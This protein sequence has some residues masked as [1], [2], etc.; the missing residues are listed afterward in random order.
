[1]IEGIKEIGDIIISEAPEKFLE[2]LALNVLSEKQGRKQYIVIINFDYEEV[3][4]ET[5][6]KY[7]WLDVAKGNKPQIYLT[8][9]GNKKFTYLFTKTLREIIKYGL[10]NNREVIDFQKVVKK[11]FAKF[12]NPITGC[13]DAR[14]FTCNG[15]NL[16]ETVAA[17]LIKDFEKAE[18]KIKLVK[19]KSEK[20]DILKELFGKDSNYK[21]YLPDKIFKQLRKN[22]ELLI[23]KDIGMNFLFP[24]KQENLVDLINEKFDSDIVKITKSK[25]LDESKLSFLKAICEEKSL[26]YEDIGL[27]SLRVLDSNYNGILVAH[28]GYRKLLEY[29]KI[30]QIFDVRH[31]NKEYREKIF[32]GVCSLCGEETWVSSNTT[33]LRFKFYMTDK[34]GFSSG[35]KGNFISNYTLC[36]S[37]YQKVM[38]G[39][40]FVENNLRSRIEDVLFYI[41]PKFTFHS[42]LS[43]DRL[44]KWGQYIKLSFNSAINLEG[45]AKFRD[46]VDNYL[47]CD[48]DKNSVILDLLFYRKSQAELRILKLVKD[49]PPSRLDIL[50]KTASEIKNK[51]DMLLGE[52][53]RWYLGLGAIYY[54]M[55]VRTQ[56]SNPVEH[57]KVL[58]LY[59][60]LL[61]GKPISYKFL[62]DQFVGL[63]QIYRFKKFNGYNI[64]RLLEK[65]YGRPLERITEQEKRSYGENE[66]PYVILS[67]NLLLLYL[68][69]LNLLEGGETMNIG[70]LNLRPPMKKYIK[71][72]GYSEP[73]IALFLLGYLIGEIGNA[74]WNRE[75]PTKPILEKI[76]Y[77]GMTVEK[78]K[79]LTNEVFEKLK[80]YKSEGRPLLMFNELIFA[81]C[82]RL[83]DRNIN[84]WH[85]SDQENVF[86]VLSGYAYATRERMKKKEGN[87]EIEQDEK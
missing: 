6:R 55:P 38:L 26:K 37:C 51:S 73:E 80:Q 66:L 32:E 39:E 62:I 40:V 87:D 43:V 53:D 69:K 85:P 25:N 84:N 30:E 64:G 36:K 52:S 46:E 47:E 31:K 34:I 83:L 3:K 42:K 27:V 1:M 22:A 82:K 48:A 9:S 58:Q 41:I 44:K 86:Y 35:L 56:N 79:R 78:L 2:S 68:R 18:G 76:T 13:I 19:N 60:A 17:R 33:N 29:E 14:K 4:E 24:F 7:L 21:N 61:T 65:R 15:K 57:R 54:L 75:S 50:R 20:K 12:F 74:Q 59:D 23:K 77:Q 28:L 45:L 49:V 5:P 72:M 11:I 63:V 71:E 70:E 67:S 10:L 16:A 81:E 8:T